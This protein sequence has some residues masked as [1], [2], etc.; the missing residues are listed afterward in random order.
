MTKVNVTIP[1]I[2]KQIVDR[3]TG[4]ADL[5]WYRFFETL[6]NRTGGSNDQ[7]DQNTQDLSNK[8]DKTTK[9][10]AGPGLAGG[11]A[12][13]D[14]VTLSLDA[15]ASQI[16]Y[17]NTSSGIAAVNVQEAIDEIAISAGSSI[18]EIMRRISLGA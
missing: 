1:R 16:A 12:L 17:D 11:G 13:S 3:S 8:V 10:I 15:T 9:V 18:N 2:D 7:I 5:T 6:L 4:F 14:D